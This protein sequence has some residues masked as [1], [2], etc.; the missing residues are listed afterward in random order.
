MESLDSFHL[1][2]EL[3]VKVSKEAE[4]QLIY[5]EFQGDSSPPDNAQLLMTMTIKLGANPLTITYETR[6]VD[7]VSYEQ[8]PLTGEWESGV[9]GDSSE[10]ALLDALLV[11]KLRL[12]DMAAEVDFLNGVPVYRLTGINPNDPGAENTVLWVGIDDFLIQQAVVEGH[13]S[14]DEYQGLVSQDVQELFQSQIFQLSRFNQPVKIVAP[15][16]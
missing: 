9:V 15:E 16:G 14:A 6:K 8:N 2:G 13:V 12:I 3:V 7:N 1:E 4:E 10:D 11:G 5:A